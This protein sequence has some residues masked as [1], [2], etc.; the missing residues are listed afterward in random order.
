L[1]AVGPEMITITLRSVLG[2]RDVTFDMR[3]FPRVRVGT[4]TGFDRRPVSHVIG[5]PEAVGVRGFSEA[6]R[7]FSEGA[8]VQDAFSFLSPAD[9]EFIIS[10][11]TPEE[12]ERTFGSDDDGDEL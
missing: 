12:W 3:A 8:F 2:R 10:G 11:V 7:A 6:C 1:N 5:V 9:R 4:V